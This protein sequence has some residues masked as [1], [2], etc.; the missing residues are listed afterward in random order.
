MAD[1]DFEVVDLPEGA[2]LFT[3]GNIYVILYIT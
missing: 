2:L 3:D 1:L